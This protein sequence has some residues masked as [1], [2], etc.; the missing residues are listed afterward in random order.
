MEM[1]R[2]PVSLWKTKTR[3][4]HRPC[5]SVVTTGGGCV[6]SRGHPP[7][8]GHLE[9]QR[10]GEGVRS[11]LGGAQQDIYVIQGGRDM[12]GAGTLGRTSQ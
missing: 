7:A 4:W 11:I 5:V 9:L 12:A 3:G 2:V 10:G 6:P 8:G 1:V